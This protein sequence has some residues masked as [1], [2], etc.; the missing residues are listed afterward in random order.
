ME[1]NAIES[2]LTLRGQDVH[3]LKEKVLR[4]FQTGEDSLPA[5]VFPMFRHEEWMAY[6]DAEVGVPQFRL[7]KEVRWVIKQIVAARAP[8]VDKRS[9]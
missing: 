5:K 6:P 9:R 8:F 3:A 4:Y 2:A 1:V 7:H